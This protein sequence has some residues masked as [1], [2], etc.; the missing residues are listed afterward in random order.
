M[1][2]DRNRLREL[3]SVFPETVMRADNSRSFG[4]LV[5][6]LL[7]FG[8]FVWLIAVT[9]NIY[10]LVVLWFLFGF[11][12]LG[13]YQFGHDTAHG[14]MFSQKRISEIVGRIVFL[15][16][17]HP[18]SKWIYGHNMVHHAKTVM[19]KGDLAWHPR[20]PE[21]Y[22]K[23]S[24]LERLLHRLYWSP[25]GA[26]IYY[27]VKMWWQGLV[28]YKLPGRPAFWDTALVIFFALFSSVAVFWANI[29]GDNWQSGLFAFTKII[30]VPFFV[31]N[32]FIGITV[33]VQH[34]NRDILWKKEQDWDY[35]NAQVFGTVNY[36]LS[37]FVNLFIHNIFYHSPHHLQPAIPFYH[38]P[39]SYAL[40]EEK[41]GRRMKT[42]KNPVYDYLISTKYCKLY[43]S[44]SEE[45]IRYG[46]KV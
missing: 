45:W 37:W 13:L 29:S 19:L 31:Q 2:V 27:T 7:V 38:L 24:F 23:M 40:L 25:F 22:N 34:I 12:L 30:L 33:Y 18:Y 44:S 35:V 21:R 39:K 6:D 4:F 32:S 16:S 20:S 26:G 14:S 15:P 10:Y 41:I 9:D 46:E 5:F 43:D 28:M 3:Q 11:N 42:G 1:V 8:I 17:L 36:Q